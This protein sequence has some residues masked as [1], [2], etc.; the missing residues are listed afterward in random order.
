MSEMGEWALWYARQDIPVFPVNPNNK[1]PYYR[2]GFKVATTDKNKIER[3]WEAHPDAMIGMPTG[4]QS[5]ISVIDVG[6]DPV[7]S[8]LNGFIRNH[9]HGT[10]KSR[11]PSGGFHQM[12]EHAVG[13]RNYQHN[14]KADPDVDIRGDGGYIILPPSKRHDGKQYCWVGPDMFSVT[15]TFPLEFQDMVRGYKSKGGRNG[16]GRPVVPEEVEVGERYPVMRSL[17]TGLFY[18]NYN[19]DRILATLEEFN[20]NLSVPLPPDQW[21]RLIN[22]VTDWLPNIVESAEDAFWDSTPILSHVRRFAQANRGAPIPVLGC[23]LARTAS[24][25]SPQ[26]RLP[27]L[28]AGRD[29]GSI[30]MYVALVGEPGAGKDQAIGISNM[31]I[32]L[33]D[34]QVFMPMRMGT[35]EGLA[36]GFVRRPKK[37]EAG[38]GEYVWVRDSV[39]FQES[40][41]ESVIKL[42][43]RQGATLLSEL[44]AGW[45]GGPLGHLFSDQTKRLHVPAHRYRLCV[46]AG[47]Q[48]TKAGPLLDDEGGGMPQRFLWLQVVDRF[49]PDEVAYDP[50]P[51]IV[52]LAHN[53]VNRNSDPVVMPV[54]DGAKAVMDNTVLRRLRGSIDDRLRSHRLQVRLRVAACL[55]LLHGDTDVSDE[56]WELSRW[57]VERS[58]EGLMICKHAVGVEAGLE[59]E[60]R[61]RRSGRESVAASDYLSDTARASCKRII[62]KLIRGDGGWFSKTEINRALGKPAYREHTESVLDELFGDGVL[63]KREFK[64]ARGRAS[65]KYRRTKELKN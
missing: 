7:P 62:L 34:D 33:G 47:V 57:V 58:D 37:E 1:R 4:P 10:A 42:G 54:C 26:V 21:G 50:A 38:V 31:C 23:L 2:G 49:A 24:A 52:S 19:N 41:I 35:G 16:H 60:R 17:A 6:A 40:E 9:R 61:G 8:E 32:E 25:T 30:N 29:F 56:W 64:P 51:L 12:Y 5:G 43:T 28:G 36:H 39:L 46:V 14:R 22:Y 44:R 11:T 3:W 18:R 27:G 65:D 13:V 59:A 48:P 15:A 63:E 53:F 45:S 55:A 20:A